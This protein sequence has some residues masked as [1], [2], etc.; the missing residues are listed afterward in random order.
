MCAYIHATSKR[1]WYRLGGRCTPALNGICSTSFSRQRP[2]DSGPSRTN[3]LS[4]TFFRAPSLG[5]STPTETQLL[6][7]RAHPDLVPARW[8]VHACS[9]WTIEKIQQESPVRLGFEPYDSPNG[10]SFFSASVSVCIGS[11]DGPHLRRMIE[12]SVKGFSSAGITRSTRA[13][14][15]GLP[16][17]FDISFSFSARDFTPQGHTNTPQSTFYYPGRAAS[18]TNTYPSRKF[19]RDPPV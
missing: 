7:R 5:I 8:R 19:P 3:S 15:M 17:G 12:W 10:V 14:A 13:R 9:E 11:V 2:F 4:L 16:H 1:T 18:A 6:H